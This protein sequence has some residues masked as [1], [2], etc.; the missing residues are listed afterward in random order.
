MRVVI[1]GGAGF[2]GTRLA[3]KLAHDGHDVS[4][5]D[6]LHAQIHGALPKPV[7][8][9]GVSYFRS[10]IRDLST[11]RSVLE[12]AEAIYHF[13]AETGTGQS[14][15]R[16]EPYVSV[17][18][19]GTA[20]LLQ[21]LSDLPRTDRQIILASSRSVYGEG[22]YRRV[23]GTGGIMR[24]GAR[25]LAALSAGQFEFKASDGVALEPIATP[26][27]LPFNPGSVYAATKAS[28]ELLLQ[29]GCAAVGARLSI[30]RLQNVYGE[31]QSLQNP[32]TGIISIFY[33]RARQGLGI[34]L[35]E[36]GIPSRDFVHVDDVVAAFEGLLGRDMPHG[37]VL[38]VGSGQATSIAELADTLCRTAQ[39]DV[40]IEVT[41]KF[42]LGDIR[43]NWADLTETQRL[44][45]FVPSVDLETGLQR[46][47]DWAGTQP[48][49]EDL[50]K[51]ADAEM[52][53]AGI[54]K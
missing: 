37:T 7:V 38:N 49:Y 47:V 54:S 45:D 52:A 31:G 18:E 5:L 26:E 44:L 10:D 4:I 42:R 16:I 39:F 53:S 19:L 34:P 35:Y 27:S 29:A 23:D 50:S 41:G 21:T 20:H 9:P 8:V 33:N 28:Q 30:L 3:S 46:F 1:T 40:P 43:H 6:N 2:I 22:A 48:I 11:A 14:M 32:Y 24:P 17:N 25:S 15:Y 13:A 51:K 12:H 36:D